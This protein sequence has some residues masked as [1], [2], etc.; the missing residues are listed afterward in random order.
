MATGKL[1]QIMDALFARAALLATTAPA[2]PIAWPEPAETF[3]PPADGKYLQVSFYPNRPAWEGVSSGRL[4]QGLLQIDVVW[5]K[6]AGLIAPAQVAAQIEA[7]FPKGAA[8]VSG[9]T[10]V[11]ITREPWTAQ[12][13]P[14]A[15]EVR[16]PVTI[17]W[18]A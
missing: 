12:P 8:Y 5:P 18:A 14:D 7:H 11:T 17:S 13:L 4:D 6:N 10:K 2:L 9:A 1:A 16:L 15:N 3:T